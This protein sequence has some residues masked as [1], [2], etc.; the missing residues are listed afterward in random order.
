MTINIPQP[1]RGVKPHTKGTARRRNLYIALETVDFTWDEDKVAD[2]RFLWIEGHD[3]G[4]MARYFKRKPL[5]VF[6]LILDQIEMGNLKAR[7]GGIYG[8]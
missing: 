4:D 3:L 1:V 2:V 8:F 7:Q 5:E 6:L